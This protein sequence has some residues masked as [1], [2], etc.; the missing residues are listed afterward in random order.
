MLRIEKCYSAKK[1]LAEFPGR[2][3]SL[4]SVKRL[5]HQIDTTGSA[6]RKTGSG[7]R[8]TARTDGNASVVEELALSQEEAP[9]THRTVRQIARETGITK[10]SVHRIIHR[11]LKLKCFK[12]K[13][14]QDLTEANKNKRLACS[15][16]LLRRYAEHSVPFI[17]F[18]D[19]KLFHV[20]PP[21]NLQNDRLYAKAGTRKKQ[22]SAD[23]LL[24]K[25]STFSKS[26]MV[27]VGVSLLG[28]TNLIFI[29]PGVKIN[30]S[31]YR[32][33]L[34]RQQLLPA[35]RSVSGDF[36]TFQQDSA[37]AHRARETVA[38]LSAETPDFI[39]PQDWPPNSPDLNP[40]D[41]AIWGILQERVYRCQIRDVD[42]LKER[43]IEE[44][45]RFDQNIIDRA[46]NQWRD[47]LRKCVRAKGGHFEHLI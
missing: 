22:L 17:W 15:R 29:D 21:V 1:L 40:V 10:S 39:S 30:G 9:G 4:A 11:D 32:D 8:R 46:V 12:K 38:L 47:R 33:T 31:Y 13:R 20:A 26:A 6:D 5:L 2:N 43:L 3:W 14:A 16:K 24:R 28:Y 7:R 37:P 19:E 27:S 25:R 23:R 41:Y 42:H 44:W 34:L 35:I 45:R 36:F 18:T